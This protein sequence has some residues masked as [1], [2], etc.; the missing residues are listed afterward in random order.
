MC[1]PSLTNAPGDLIGGR[2]VVPRSGTVVESRNPASPTE[3]VW[4]SPT[5]TAHVDAAIAAAR[6]ASREWAATPFETRA[7]VLRRFQSICKSREPQIAA[8][9]ADETGK[10]MWD[11]RAE[12]SLLA[13]KVDVTLDDSEF[14]A[15]RRV[16]G[17]NV[18]INATR[19]GRACF[20]PHGTLAVVGPYNFPCHLPNGH[21]VPAIAL[22]NTVVFKPSDKSPACGQ[23]LGE[24][25]AEALTQEHAPSGVV[26]VV[27]GGVDVAST[28]VTHA[29]IDGV[30]FTG[31]W[32]VGRKIIEGN[33]D[34]PGRML[35]LEM[36]G[37]NA[38]VVMPD[39]DLTLALSECVRSAFV[40]TGQRCTCTRR[41]IVHR[42]IAGRFIP[43]LCKAA[44]SLI[45]GAPRAKHPVFMGPLISE[46][47]RRDVLQAQ[48]TF[49]K[50]GGEVLVPCSVPSDGADSR[51]GWFLTAGVIRVTEFVPRD[52][53]SH[54]GSDNEVFGPLLRVCVVDS[55]EK[56]IEQANATRY[57]LAAAIFTASPDSASRFIS[58]VRAGC[59]NVNTGTAGASSK[60]PFGGLGLSGNHRPAGAFSLDYCAFPV[61]TMT[62]T[63]HAPTS[64]EG[65]RIETQ[66][67]AG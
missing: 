34:R 41:L 8:L 6:G 7:K 9:I 46:G 16:S 45:V 44:S 67:L 18:S 23:L 29:D 52:D 19:T 31:S 58:E 20:K 47:A 38:A 61:A 3:I 43:A 11:A 15:L 14:G 53:A 1:H 17:F 12:A 24:L 65:M 36:G 33:L 13:A 4:Q 2:P 25:F 48:L 26:N 57:G 22:G 21:I 30:L 40:S 49:A 66:W 35:A 56:A 10:A 37:N 55:L 28:L 63:G 42:D 59:I 54:A 27:H 64:V 60:L 51:P 5:S 32:P 62:E 50:A 39:A